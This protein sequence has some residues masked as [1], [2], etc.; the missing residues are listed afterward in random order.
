MVAGSVVLWEN[1]WPA[2]KPA[3]GFTDVQFQWNFDKGLQVKE[4]ENRLE[5]D[6]QGAIYHL[7]NSVE[8]RKEYSRD[9]ILAG[10]LGVFIPDFNG[11]HQVLDCSL[12]IK[13]QTILQL[14]HLQTLKSVKLNISQ[15]R[16]RLCAGHIF[17]IPQQTLQPHMLT[18]HAVQ[19]MY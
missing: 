4:L 16:C 10:L 3:P 8:V 7:V 17:S 11:T 2:K 9:T 5:L 14:L 13:L 19:Q 6:D 18:S 15:P 1:I 12:V